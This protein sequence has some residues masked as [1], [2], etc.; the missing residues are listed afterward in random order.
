MTAMLRG[1]K[2]P[3]SASARASSS[4]VQFRPFGGSY[5][6]EQLER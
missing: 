2:K 1:A 6:T 3:S 4:M 5:Y